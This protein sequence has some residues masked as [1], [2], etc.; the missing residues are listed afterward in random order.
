MRLQDHNHELHED[1]ETLKGLGIMI[2]A[3]EEGYLLQI[4]TKPS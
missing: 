4:F 1:I 3:D 2:D